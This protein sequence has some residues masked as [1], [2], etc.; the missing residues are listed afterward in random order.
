MN[1]A[2]NNNDDQNTKSQEC[3][4]TLMLRYGSYFLRIR[5][6]YAPVVI[7]TARG[8]HIIHRTFT[9]FRL[10]NMLKFL[11]SQTCMFKNKTV[12]ITCNLKQT[13]VYCVNVSSSWIA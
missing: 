10:G 4:A 11:S 12:L 7:E 1:K 5:F 2:I 3:T 6:R 9:V 8:D 13:C